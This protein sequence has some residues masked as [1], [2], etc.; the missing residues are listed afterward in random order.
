MFRKSNFIIRAERLKKTVTFFSFLVLLLMAACYQRFERLSVKSTAEGIIFSHPEMDE[1]ISQENLCVFGRMSVS[2]QSSP[3]DY[4][5][6]MW[7]LEN[8]ESGF[9]QSTEPMK[10]CYIV[11][12]E[13]LPQTSVIINPKP[14]REGSYE[15]NGVVGIYNQKR[16]LL[17]DLSFIDKFSL[18]KDETGNL[19]V[20][21][22]TEK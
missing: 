20:L 9:Q 14:L 4:K 19:I 17:K 8:T 16:E 22:S 10:K 11:Y 2:R 5:E 7:M 18:K 6:Q 13:T 21:P 1:A 15:V 3:N 12:G